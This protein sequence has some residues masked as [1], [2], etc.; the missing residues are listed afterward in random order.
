MFVQTAGDTSLQNVEQSRPRRGAVP[1]PSSLQLVHSSYSHTINSN[2]FPLSATKLYYCNFHLRVLTEVRASPLRR[3][4]STI[5]SKTGSGQYTTV[6][7]PFHAYPT[8]QIPH[9]VVRYW[10]KASAVRDRRLIAWIMAEIMIYTHYK[11]KTHFLLH[12]KLST[13]HLCNTQIF[14]FYH[15]E[16]TLQLST[17]VFPLNV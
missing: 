13:P 16:S 6:P 14:I 15:T 2:N 17:K 5:R 9:S 7:L 3:A 10:T 1:L 12:I 8:P 4:T 11:F